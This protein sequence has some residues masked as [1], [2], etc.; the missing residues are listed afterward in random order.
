M[1]PVI[2]F[3]LLLVGLLSALV[4]AISVYE[5]YQSA[6]KQLK[7][8]ESNLISTDTDSRCP[9]KSKRN[10]RK[11]N[12]NQNTKPI[13]VTRNKLQ[14]FTSEFNRMNAAIIQ[15]A[16]DGKMT[17]ATVSTGNCSNKIRYDP[18]LTNTVTK[19][20][21][22]KASVKKPEVAS[23]NSLSLPDQTEEDRLTTT[24]YY[25]ASS[26]VR[27]IKGKGGRLVKAL[28]RKYG[29]E[30]DVSAQNADGNLVISGGN[31][32]IRQTVEADIRDRMIMT[33][34]LPFVNPIVYAKIKALVDD[35]KL[36]IV[37]QTI[38]SENRSICFKVLAK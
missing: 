8:P 1:E 6:N 16:D 35:G 20:I 36:Q 27:R 33:I 21:P 15:T 13:S 31:E 9:R 28:E 3:L 17:L 12:R 29:V 2:I 38:E 5:K 26:D 4:S 34:S 22:N 24:L 37:H 10:R 19:G 30:I 23:L 18:N 32:A 14:G 11:R 25:V 7:S